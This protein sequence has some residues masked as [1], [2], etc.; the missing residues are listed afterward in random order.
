MLFYFIF[1]HSGKYAY[2]VS[3]ITVIIPSY[4]LVINVKGDTIRTG[5]VYPSEAPEFTPVFNEIRDNQPV[6]FCVAVC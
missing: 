6:V 4:V 5:S 1:I 2:F 3:D